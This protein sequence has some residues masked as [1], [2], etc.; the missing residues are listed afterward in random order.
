MNV[1]VYSHVPLWISH[2][3]EAVE[4]ALRESSN[5]NNVFFL[6]CTG[7]L[8]FCPANLDKKKLLCQACRLQTNKTIK[9]LKSKGIN[10]F[11]NLDDFIKKGDWNFSTHE[12]LK[13]EEYKGALIGNLVYSSIATYYEDSYFSVVGNK[14][15]INQLMSDA[16][17]LYDQT[18]QIIEK[19]NIESLYYWNGRRHCEGVMGYAA[20]NKKINFSS[21]ISG[22]ALDGIL[23]RNNC[24]TVHDLEDSKK[25]IEA[26]KVH[27]TQGSP[28]YI[29]SINK[30]S[31]YYGRACGLS[32]VKGAHNYLGF[33]DFSSK[34]KISESLYRDLKNRKIVSI[35]V[36]TYSEFSGVKGYDC[37][38]Y[39][40]EDFYMG[41]S[42]V[43][44]ILSKHD[45]VVAIVRWHPNSRRLTGIEKT[46]LE[47]LVA[48]ADG[49]KVRHVLPLD[50]ADSYDLIRKSEK[51]IAI[52]S[53]IAMEAVAMG[54]PVIFLAHNV[55]EDLD[56]IYVP[57]DISELTNLISQQ[58][59]VKNQWLC[60]VFSMYYITFGNDI[61]RKVSQPRRGC[62]RVDSKNIKSKLTYILQYFK[63]LF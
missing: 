25:N 30:A 10:E 53:T 49:D 1:L 19:K 18:E 52:G 8:N 16:V 39:F 58:L 13:A 5:G 41:V 4:I 33:Y 56:C 9:L 22:G 57:K 21:F 24:Y 29:E 51:V 27:L 36:G 44:K 47:N 23:I 55:F 63:K 54:K 46:K 32:G 38:G 45:D 42:Q 37:S 20:R 43:L 12:A 48:Q 6:S 35:F 62:F 3:A 14:K 34:F 31:A 7:Q 11:I 61:F 26:I 40:F 50:R 17:N 2:H 28:K 60:L 59:I 15:F